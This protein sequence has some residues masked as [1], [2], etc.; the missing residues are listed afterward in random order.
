M[1]EAI[2]L[3]GRARPAQRPSHK[4]LA[5]PLGW[6]SAAANVDARRLLLG[7]A[8]RRAVEALSD[9][10]I[11]PSPIC[12]LGGPKGSGKSMLAARFAASFPAGQVID[13]AQNSDEIALFH[14]INDA[15]ARGAP[16]L[17]VAKTSADAWQPQLPDL[18]TRIRA[19]LDL[20]LEEPDTA[21]FAAVLQQ[22]MGLR[23]LHLS[24]KVA[25]FVA[26]RLPRTWAVLA[27]TVEQLAIAAATGSGSTLSLA[28][29]RSALALED[30]VR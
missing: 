16:M 19:A 11:W 18:A 30:G 4:Q 27:A 5:L 13:N 6:A 21:L 7:E 14:Q 29:A 22:E 8:N 23:H 25:E 20:E 24:A 15:L 26:L 28:M 3:F 1:N 2:D 10:S 9:P 12:V 17:L